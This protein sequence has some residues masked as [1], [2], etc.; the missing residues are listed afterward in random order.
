[1]FIEIRLF[2]LKKNSKIAYITCYE[3]NETDDSIESC[4][5]RVL[6]EFLE[7]GGF[8][9]ERQ[10]ECISLGCKRLCENLTPT[11][12]CFAQNNSFMYQ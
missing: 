10:T 3:L 2:S 6:Y 8:C 7:G 5:G 11:R 1:M 12:S 9:L 4:S